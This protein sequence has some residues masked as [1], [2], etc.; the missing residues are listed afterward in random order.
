MQTSATTASDQHPHSPIPRSVAIAIDLGGTKVESAIVD[1]AGSVLADTRFR[2]ATGPASTS[3]QLAAAVT[4][5]VAQAIAAVPA[6]ATLAGIGIGSAGPI[7]VAT[8]AVSPL[9]LPVW[10]E[11][12]LR[13]L[14]Q[15]LAPGV[16]VRLR[17]DGLCITLAEHWVGAASNVETMGRPNLLVQGRAN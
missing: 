16:P 4:S 15:D 7:T 5:V 13:D 2:A 1:E 17:M 12:P 14:V 11:Y 10:R 3:A 8:G 9:N 6:D